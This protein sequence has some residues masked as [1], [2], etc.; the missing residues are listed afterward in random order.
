MA[1]AIFD[2]PAAPANEGNHLAEGT[3]GVFGVEMVGPTLW[4]GRHLLR[5]VAHD[6]AE[7]LADEGA[8]VIA[9]RLGRV[10][11][12]RTDGEQVLEALARALELGGDRL[13]FGLERFEV[14]HALAHG[15]ELVDELLLRLLVVVGRGR[16]RLAV[17]R[18]DV[19][20]ES[21]AAVSS[22]HHSSLRWG[23]LRPS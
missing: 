12:G 15:R 10:D 4:V 18:P 11:D 23:G 7:I 16:R 22:V 3:R 13:A 6:G 20:L 17:R 8:G 19:L 14:P 1:E 2:A 21:V 9:G 5:R